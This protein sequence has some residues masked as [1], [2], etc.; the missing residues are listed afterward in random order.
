MHPA[1]ATD[2]TLFTGSYTVT[3]A[4]YAALDAQGGNAGSQ[5]APSQVLTV[6][7]P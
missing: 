5:S 1:R 4:A 6:N 2:V 3:V 7:V